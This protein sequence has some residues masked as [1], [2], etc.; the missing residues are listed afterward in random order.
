MLGDILSFAGKLGGMFMDKDANEDALAF[1]QANAAANREA[2]REFAQM[3]IRW[4]AADARAAG[5]HPAFAMGAS[6]HSFSP[7]S[8]DG[9]SSTNYS[10][11]L[12]SM[13]QDLGRAIT[14]T[15]TAK[16]RDDNFTANVKRLQLEGAQLDND[17]K[18]ASLASS[19]AKLAATQSPPFPEAS[20]EG[21]PILSLGDGKIITDPNVANT[22]EFTKRY[23]EG[24][25]WLAGPMVAWKDFQKN[26]PP[27][28]TWIER[29]TKPIDDWLKRSGRAAYDWARSKW[30]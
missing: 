15:S 29:Q 28:S 14:A 1:Q 2:Q 19:V 16:E 17:I 30:R 6:T 13:G 21:R 18:R 24:A 4:K 26:Y 12:G 23:G 10:G 22:E 9:G 11:A 7:V 27:G 5:L 20:P 8:I 25:D 3:G